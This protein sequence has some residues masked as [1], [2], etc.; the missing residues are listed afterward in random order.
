MKKGNNQT[1]R[2]SPKTCRKIKVPTDEET[3]ILKSMRVVK[4][5]VR[6]L[7]KRRSEISLT[8][9]SGREAL[10]EELN[11]ELSLLK[12][13]WQQWEKQRKKAAR[14]RM[15]LLGHEDV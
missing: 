13:E 10:L 6:I 1:D 14:A 4:E 7:K 3:E 9:A 5:R 2:T 15:I 11:N 8:P 12:E